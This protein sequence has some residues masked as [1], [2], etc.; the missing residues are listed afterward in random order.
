MKAG[1]PIAILAG[2]LFYF[3]PAPLTPEGHRMLAV[4]A[5]ATTLWITESLPLPATA[6]VIAVLVILFG[7]ASS[8][9]V[10]S[11]FADPILFLFI[12]SFILAEAM[13]VHRLDQRIANAVLRNSWVRAKAGRMIFL[14][15]CICFFISMWISNTATTAM[16]FPIGLSIIRIFPEE[17]RNKV[18]QLILLMTSFAA[19]IGGMA[20]PVG[21][22]PNL[23][24]IAMINNLVHRSVSFFEFMRY[25]CPISILIFLAIY[26]TMRFFL[27]HECMKKPMH[28]IELP[29]EDLQLRRAQMNVTIA[30]LVTVFLW[31]L[32]GFVA[33]AGGDSKWWEAHLPESVAALIGAVLLFL[34]PVDWKSRKFTIT[35]KQAE[36]INWGIILLFG[37][38]L[39]LGKFLFKTGVA[40]YFGDTLAAI[41]PFH[42][43]FSY[44]LLFTLVAIFISEFTSNTA[45]ANMILPISIAVCQSAGI[46]PYRTALAATF[47][48]SLGFMLPVSTAPNAIVFSSGLI[49]VR[50]M[51]RYGIVLDVLGAVLVAIGMYFL[52]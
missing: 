1:I 8:N 36:N 48:S 40:K 32:P 16:M 10:F 47:A 12:G 46:D 2:I 22:P 51:I 24:G 7:V 23:I 37:G 35:W 14:Y 33:L 18:A 19:S 17:G 13:Q 9:E 15:A 28:D 26:F 29:P 43:E 21:T 39:I 30:F 50:S 38:G 42:S 4:T 20:T 11:V 31:L 45:S 34:L 41:Y 44:I 25:G 5:I 49:P 52:G 6:L 3:L 27:H